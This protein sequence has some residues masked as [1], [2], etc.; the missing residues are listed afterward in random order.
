MLRLV[1]ALALALA[2]ALPADASPLFTRARDTAALE[3]TAISGIG[4][5]QPLRLDVRALT[6]LCGR[7][8]ATVD[9]FPLGRDRTATLE[10]TRFSPFPPTARA[11]V[12]E[13]TGP[14][15]LALPDATY[16]RGRVA[17]E[18]ESRVLLIAGPDEV[19]GF[20]VSGSDV[21]PFGR[22]ARGTHLAYALRDVNPAFFPP[23]G[24]FCQNDLH[25][26]A[27]SL[28]A[29]TAPPVAADPAI[30][31]LP[32]K[33]AEIAIETDEELRAKFATD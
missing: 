7:D 12:M 15:A 13:A 22:G 14:R 8:A 28:P 19:H 20:I 3:R 10:V 18:P 6:D 30:A 31:G 33:Q 29:P 27:V 25:P 11:E 26:E 23:P 16:F 1:L 17:G 24:D 4:R 32:L 21:F 5:V 9:G 2:A